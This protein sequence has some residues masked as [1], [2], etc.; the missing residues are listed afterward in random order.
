MTSSETPFFLIVT[1]LDRGVF[2]VEGPMTDDRPWHAA[3]RVGPIDEKDFEETVPENEVEPVADSRR[4][5]GPSDT[6][7]KV[8]EKRCRYRAACGSRLSLRRSAHAAC[9]T[10]PYAAGYRRRGQTG[11]P[12]QV[13]TGIAWSPA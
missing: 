7:L 12:A 3:V 11:R 6:L 13:K 9:A 10:L 5:S 1:D 2:S 4:T 8:F